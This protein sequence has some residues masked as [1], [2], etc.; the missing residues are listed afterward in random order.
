MIVASGFG[1][2]ITITIWFFL[3]PN[4][5]ILDI[6]VEEDNSITNEIVSDEICKKVIGAPAEE[7]VEVIT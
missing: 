3:V 4:P 2:I 1:L 7:I 6:N 5:S